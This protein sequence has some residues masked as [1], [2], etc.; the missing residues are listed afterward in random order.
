M[1]SKVGIDGSKGSLSDGLE[2]Q[3]TGGNIQGRKLLAHDKA[4]VSGSNTK[5]VKS[6]YYFKNVSKIGTAQ[7]RVKGSKYFRIKKGSKETVFERLG[8][9]KIMP[10]FVVRKTRISNVKPNPF[11]SV[12]AKLASKLTAKL[13]QNNAEFQFKKHLK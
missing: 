11:I 13:Y 12:S 4:R 3:E 6:K 9:N 5:K 1:V 8:K 7:K 2:K 10:V